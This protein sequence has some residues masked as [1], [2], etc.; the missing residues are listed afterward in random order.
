MYERGKYTPGPRLDFVSRL[1]QRGGLLFHSHDALQILQRQELVLVFRLFRARW[2][3]TREQGYGAQTG[4]PLH[5]AYAMPAA[6]HRVVGPARR[7]L[8]SLP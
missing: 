1:N 5:D 2:H 7:S 3:A 4:W 6:G 8:L